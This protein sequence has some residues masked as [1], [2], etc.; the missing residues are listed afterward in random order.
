MQY[1]G[2]STAFEHRVDTGLRLDT[3]ISAWEA[4]LPLSLKDSCQGLMVGKDSA[5]PRKVK[6]RTTHDSPKLCS[7]EL[8]KNI[9]Q[10]ELL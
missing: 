9:M 3:D 5:K 2:E 6:G 8:W 7:C 1:V 10:V 4:C